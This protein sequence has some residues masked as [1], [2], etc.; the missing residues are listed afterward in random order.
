MLIALGICDFGFA[1]SEK[2]VLVNAAREGARIGSLPGYSCAQAEERALLYM[3]T[4]GV[5]GTAACEYAN[6]S[7][8]GLEFQT[9]QVTVTFT[10]RYTIIGRFASLASAPLTAT[11]V[12][13]IESMGS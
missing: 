7:A 5:T 4:S 6:L 12:M 9:V 1:F 8:G 3:Q 11:V 10:H 13:R 2:E